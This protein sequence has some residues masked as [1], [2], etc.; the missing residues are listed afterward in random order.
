MAENLIEVDEHTANVTVPED[1][2]LR[3]AASVRVAFQA[4][5]NRSRHAKGR[6]DAMQ[7]ATFTLSGTATNVTKHT[8]TLVSQTGSGFSV[9]SDEITVPAAG[10]YLLLLTGYVKTTN[11][12]DPASGDVVY[13]VAGSGGTFLTR[14]RRYSAATSQ[15]VPV[16]GSALINITNAGTQK[17]SFTLPAGGETHEFDSGN[18]VVLARVGA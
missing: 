17:I 7:V 18:D 13:V 12:N 1:G 6:I 9:A 5:A 2:D 10:W 8:V 11:T 15:Y 3:S 16:N 4:L 14:F